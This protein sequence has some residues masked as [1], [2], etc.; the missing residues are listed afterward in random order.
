MPKHRIKKAKVVLKLSELTFLQMIDFSKHVI[1]SMSGNAYFPAPLPA[2]NTISTNIANLDAAVMLANTRTPSATADKHAKRKLLHD[3]MTSLGFYVE[4]IA[5]QD[6]A[7][8]LTIITSAGMTPKKDLPP[9]P[10]G[11]RLVLTGV[12]GEVK[13]LTDWVRLAG[14]KWEYTTTPEDETSWIETD[15]MKRELLLSGLTTGLR[16][17]FR[18]AVILHTCGPYSQVINTIVL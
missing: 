9:K 14:Y 6:P 17:Y 11:F 16:Y 12:P 5:N 13:L 7:N 3:S 2:L 10:S 4:A 18:V 1:S 15:S 8:A